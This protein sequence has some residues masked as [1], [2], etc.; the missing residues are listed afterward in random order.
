MLSVEQYQTLLS[1]V[2][3]INKELQKNGVKIGDEAAEAD[4]AGDA[5][6]EAAGKNAAEEDD[7]K[8]PSKSTKGKK[9]KVEKKHE[10]AQKKPKEKKANIEATSDEDDSE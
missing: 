7:D 4:A 8:K 3:A 9:E 6:E 5:D 2:P 10:P 1:T